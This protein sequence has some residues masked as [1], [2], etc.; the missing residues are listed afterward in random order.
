MWK[1]Q[2][3]AFDAIPPQTLTELSKLFP[4]KTIALRCHSPA[5]L[6]CRTFNAAE[7]EATHFG[8]GTIVFPWDCS[9][10]RKRAFAQRYGVKHIP[11]YLVVDERMSKVITLQTHV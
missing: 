6:S 10:V 8:D 5:C 9:D 1:S 3:R 11:S 2:V 4:N 7:Y